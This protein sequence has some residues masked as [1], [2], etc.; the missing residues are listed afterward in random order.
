[1]IHFKNNYSKTVFMLFGLLISFTAILAQ[2]EKRVQPKWWFGYSVAANINQYNGTTQMLNAATTVP[3]AFHKGKSVRPYASFLLEYRPNKVVG[4]MLN[5]AYDNRSARFNQVMAPCNCPADLSTNLSYFSIEPSLRLA[6]FSSAFYLFAGPTIGIN[7]NKD[8]VYVQD[9]QV[10]QRGDFSDIRKTMI[11]AQAGAGI[12]IPLSKKTNPSQVTLSPF[13]SFQTNLFQAPRTVETWDMYTVRAGLALKFGKVAT[14]APL[15]QTPQAPV[16]LVRIVTVKESNLQFSVRAPKI[17]PG[18][19]QVK[20]LF[21]L[22][23]SVFFNG[24]SS[25]IPSRYVQLSK[26]G[27]NDFKE[28][29]LQEEQ[30]SNLTRGRSERQMNVYYNILNIVGDRMRNNPNSTILL[31]GA[32]DKNATEGKAMAENVKQYLVNNYAIADSRIETAGREKP[33]IPSEQPGGTKELELLREG[34]RR[35]DI[36]STSPEMLLEVGGATSPFLRPVQIKTY[37]QDPL[38]THVIFTNK[39]ATELLSSWNVEMKN[40]SGVVQNFGPYYADQGSVSGKTILAN[41]E[42]GN[43][44][45]TMV[46]TTKAGDIIKRESTVSVAKSPDLKQEGLRYSILFDFD[47]SNAIAEYEKFLTDVVAPLIPDN[48]TAIIH[49]HTDIIGEEKYNH[50]L[51]HS[52]AENT[53]LI[54]ERATNRLGRRNVKFEVFGFGAEAASAPFEN[55]YPEERFYN[56]TV[57]IDII[58]GN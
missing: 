9:K 4:F 37:Q 21:P 56:R 36:T 58:P 46:G 1:M 14:A 44:Q 29:G 5:L 55:K 13:A 47:K 16:E 49:G 2:T 3:T 31:T 32:A 23:N 42:S 27:S 11:S 38:D 22:R 53:K 10:D 41:N 45:V 8:F 12:D 24:G 20:E 35:V 39:G 54:L 43:Y 57:I 6:P 19:R 48:G 30:P 33:V 28:S 52:R 15:K 51:S 50:Q 7:I 18:E 26:T 40:E 17:V 25:E 34:D